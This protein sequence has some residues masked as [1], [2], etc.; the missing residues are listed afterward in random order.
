M[1]AGRYIISRQT[2]KHLSGAVLLY[3]LAFESMAKPKVIQLISFFLPWSVN[4]KGLK[5]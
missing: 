5:K 1:G 2:E 4:F 3:K